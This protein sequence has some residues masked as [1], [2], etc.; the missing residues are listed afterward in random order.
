MPTS[1]CGAASTLLAFNE[2]NA[3]A[4]RTGGFFDLPT[5]AA[6]DLQLARAQVGS[7]KQE[8]ILDVQG[9]FIDTPKGNTKNAE[10]FLKLRHGVRNRRGNPEQ[11]LGSPRKGAATGDG[12]HGNECIQAEF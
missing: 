7:S 3:A 2:A 1:A 5:D 8:F 6:L 4:G 9:H 10:V 11:L 12:V